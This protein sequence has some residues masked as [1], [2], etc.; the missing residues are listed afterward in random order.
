MPLTL[1]AHWLNEIRN[2]RPGGMV[3]DDVY[4]HERGVAGDFT[5][6]A[7][8]RLYRITIEPMKVAEADVEGVP[9]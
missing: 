5:D 3:I 1:C 4:Y 7:T 6:P 8:G 9:V 2:A